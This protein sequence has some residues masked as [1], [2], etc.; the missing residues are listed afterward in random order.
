M[1][2]THVPRTARHTSEHSPMAQLRSALVEDGLRAWDGRKAVRNPLTDPRERRLVDFLLGAGLV[3]DGIALPGVPFPLAET[4]GIA[5][6]VIAFFRAPERSLRRFGLLAVV[7]AVLVVY[8]A[9][10]SAAND[11]D[12]T[13]RLTRI[14]ILMLLVYAYASERLDLRASLLG[15]GAGLLVNVPLFYAGIS[16]D[17]YG[18]YLTGVLGDK[19]VAGMAYALLPVLLSAT[20]TAMRTKILYL[21]LGFGLTFLTGSRTSLAALFCATVWIVFST[22][23]G[24]VFRLLL[25]GAMAWLVDWAERTLADLSVFG[26]RTGTDWF[27]E[28]IHEASWAKTQAA[29][30]YGE[31]LSTAYVQLENTTMFFHN[32]YWGLLTEGGYFF[33]LVIVGAY[34]FIGLR[35]LAVAAER[36]PTRV[37]VEAATVVIFVV[38]LQ[39]GEVFITVMGAMLLAC[40]LLLMADERDPQ[41]LQDKELLRRERLAETVRRRNGYTN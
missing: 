11:V 13:R 21:V 9:V 5:L 8:L 16:P 40:G 20:T 29:P 24:P 39:L 30:W 18:G 38:S 34:V 14:V 12:P 6:L 10:G 41:S 7:L 27:R 25:I 4:C 2:S 19:N 15:M 3:C 35:P 1:A 26:D 22:Y 28:R 37:A 31:G 36:T 23:L 33:L 17:A 32:S